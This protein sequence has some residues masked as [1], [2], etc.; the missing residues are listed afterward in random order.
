MIGREAGVNDREPGGPLAGVTVLEFAGLTPVSVAGMLLAGMGAD[1]IRV[2]RRDHP[3]DSPANTLR[4]GRRS[5]VLDL[6][7]PDGVRVARRLAAAADVLIEGYRPGVMERLGLG[8]QALQP[9]NPRLIYGRLTGWGQD[10]PCAMM[11][12]HDI[13]YLALTGALYPIGPAGG[14]PVPPLN[15]V[16]DLG[17]GTM[18]LLTGVLAAL[19]ER[20]GSGRGQVV[21]AAM[22]D[23]VPTL[24]ATV[25]RAR[26]TGEWHDQR[27]ANGFDGGAPFYRAYTC[28]DGGYLAV[29]A[30]EPQFY[31]RFVAGLGFDPSRLPP[32]WDRA[33][34]PEVGARFE[35]R[36]ATR[37]R[38]E[39]A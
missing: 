15:Y 39:W 8:P 6:K 35:A 13:T 31:Q 19:H 20:H 37:T 22:V 32:Q 30:F 27:G 16:A 34:W 11:A 21:D 29:G 24:A 25:L 18:F 36:I 2:D 1:V 38:D 3:A 14:P 4:R 10:G 26:A 33:S 28:R 23:A 12:G 9:D 5:I 7:H 17:A